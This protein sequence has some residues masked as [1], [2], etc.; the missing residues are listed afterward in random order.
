MV[1]AFDHGTPSKTAKVKLL[2]DS[3]VKKTVLSKADW[4]TIKVEEGCHKPKLNRNKTNFKPFETDLKLPIQGRTKCQLMATCGKHVDTLV[5][6]VEGERQSLLRLK[7]GE[8]LGII[9]I[10]PEGQFTVRQLTAEVRTTP[11]PDSIVSG[12]QTQ[13]EINEHMKIVMGKCQSLFKGIG[14]AK[15]EPMPIQVDPEVKSVQQRQR[16]VAFQYKQLFKD[17]IEELQKEGVVSGPLNSKSARGWIS[18]VITHKNWNDKKIRVN[19]DTKP[20]A[21]AVKMSHFPIPTPQ[22]LCHNFLGSDW[23]SVVDLN[24]AFHQF[25]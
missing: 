14:T 11:G 8:A 1:T 15:V 4:K 13:A 17:H 23:F 24:H 10:T 18:N 19:L 6:V 16:P 9:I 12:G 20:I 5:Y 3:G 22:K 25:E 2:I 7:D 21:N